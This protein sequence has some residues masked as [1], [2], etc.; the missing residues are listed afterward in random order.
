LDVLAALAVFL[1]VEAAAGVVGLA[2]GVVVVVVVVGPAGAYGEGYAGCI[3]IIDPE[4]CI[5]A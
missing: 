1:V 5:G 4:V 2:A 3:A